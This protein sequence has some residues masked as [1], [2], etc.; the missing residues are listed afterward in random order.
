MAQSFLKR[1]YAVDVIDLDNKKFIPQ[2]QYN[3]FIDNRTNLARIAPLLGKDCIK[4]FLATNAYWR[5]L[6]D[7][8]Q[9]RIQDIQK[10][11]GVTLTPRRSIEPFS[12]EEADCIVSVCGKSANDT[13]AFFNKKIYSVPLSTTHEFNRR[14][15]EY[16]KTRNTFIW[17]GGAGAAHKG[18]DLVLESFAAMPEYRLLVC[19]KF[20]GEKDFVD[21]YQQE[22]YHTPNIT[23]VGYIDP[24]GKEFERIRQEAI[25][26]VYPS[27]SEGC[28][29]SVVVAMHAGFIP[30]VS[31]E[32]GVEVGEFGTILPQNTVEEIQRAV[33]TLA[34]LPAQTL[35]DKSIATWEYARRRHTREKFGAEFRNV[36]N[37]I[38]IK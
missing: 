22:L 5:A 37:A 19:G 14:A 36:I 16:E 4:I 26:I 29:S 9:A 10:R 2:R 8:E 25:G 12:V 34:K 15:K 28:A 21:A 31:F 13:Y 23:S 6:N 17:F 30:I 7:A 35:R 24:G 1:G 38:D 18:L 27:S 3:F 33:H 32:T 20:E 11:R